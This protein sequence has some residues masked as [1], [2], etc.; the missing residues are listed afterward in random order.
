[1]PLAICV[2]KIYLI[3]FHIVLLHTEFQIGILL[4]KFIETFQHMWVSLNMSNYISIRTLRQMPSSI[5]LNKQ[6]GLPG[7][8]CIYHLGRKL[9]GFNAGWRQ[10]EIRFF[11]IFL[12][13]LHAIKPRD[14]VTSKRAECP[15]I[16][17]VTI[18]KSLY[19]P[20]THSNRVMNHPNSQTDF[21]HYS[22]VLF[23]FK[24]V[25]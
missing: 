16:N 8:L 19:K 7:H 5:Y 15:Q 22:K 25:Q 3:T 2:G 4:R 13:Q 24:L 21:T 6:I 18:F 20:T 14:I 12:W 23:P 17:I 11:Y 9:M 10:R 1:M